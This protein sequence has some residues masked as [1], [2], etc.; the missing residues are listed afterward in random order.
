M[1][2]KELIALLLNE[3][4][5]ALVWMEKPERCGD[6]WDPEQWV[7][8]EVESRTDEWTDKHRVILNS[9]RRAVED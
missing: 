2:V 9:T 5:D 4:M 3:P 7:V 6:Y 1:T 8:T